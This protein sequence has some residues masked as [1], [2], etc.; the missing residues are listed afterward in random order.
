[1][2]GLS[3]TLAAAGS[4]RT[5]HIGSVGISGATILAGTN[6]GSDGQAG[7]AGPA[8]DSHVAAAIG[9]ISVMGPATGSLIAA[10][11]DPPTGALPALGDP[12][13]GG[14]SSRI[15]SLYIRGQVDSSSRFVAGAFG[16]VAIPKKIRDIQKDPR[17][18]TT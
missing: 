13:L 14:T 1:M 10:G 17:F 7:G 18:S 6:L 3:G 8:A 9:Q 5:I 2:L 11:I 16:T 12:V 15:G 4:I